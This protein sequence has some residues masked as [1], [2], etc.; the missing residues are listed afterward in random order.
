MLRDVAILEAEVARPEA[1]RLGEG[2]AWDARRQE[3]L[4][5]DITGGA[6]HRWMPATGEHD[7]LSVDG[8]VSAAVPRAAGGLVLAVGH[9]L[10]LRDDD[11]AQRVVASVETD[12][13]DNRFNDCRCDPQ[14]R[15]WAGTM[16]KP[17]EPGAAGL[18]RLTAEGELTRVLAG[19]TISNG[20]GWS[21]AGDELYFIDSTTQGVDAFD[22]DGAAGTLGERRRLITI[23]PVDGLPDGLAVDVQGGIWIALFGGGV[24]RGYSPSGVL[25]TVIALPTSNPTCPAFGG[26]ELDVLYV[27]TATHRLSPE[28]LDAQPAAGALF[29][30][31]PGVRGL[32]ATPFAG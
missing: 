14:G 20:L 32:P 8:E 29:A 9:D 21:P 31:R 2:T 25:E 22:F 12:L 27:T 3:L 19:T 16:S 24:V 5:V 13:E 10:V 30:A 23:D 1:N 11:G 7:R 18:Y 17:R 28:Q 26:P 15:L 6:V 4:W